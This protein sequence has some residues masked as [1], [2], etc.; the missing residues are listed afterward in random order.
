MAREKKPIELRTVEETPHRV[1]EIVR[2]EKDSKAV[3][4]MKERVELRPAAEARLEVPLVTGADAKRT[5]EPGVEAL[6]ENDTAVMQA[7]EA[8][9]GKT[10]A[11]RKPLPWGWFALLG[12]ILLGAVAW[13][14]ARM[15]GA[16]QEVEKAQQEA[17]TKVI[18]AEATDEEIERSLGRM[19]EVVRQFCL[20][21]S[22]DEM[23]RWVRH[24]ERVRPLMER[25]YTATPLKPLGYQRQ[26]GFQGAMMGT[27]NSYW[28]V[29]VVLADGTTKALLVEQDG[30]DSFR[31]DWETAV[32]YQPMPWDA[33]ALERPAG[34]TLDFRVYV[35]ED[36]FFS[37]EFANPAQYTSF[38]LTAPGADETLWGYVPKNSPLESTLR[39]A[40][41]DNPNP[42]KPVAMLLRLGLPTGLG[43]RRGVVI[44]QVLSKRWL[45]G[46]PPRTGP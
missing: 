28:V 33:Y 31:V 22:V 27:K 43:S 40:L 13:S 41:A 29:K 20:A 26:K 24:P 10:E 42:Y 9:W 46:D 4:V 23:V 1:E 16:R 19:E 36:H 3:K 34:T 7:D 25:H 32:I 45:P 39:Q 37:H 17:V 15:V 18:A 14:V 30:D 2:L 5:H 12:L 38:R 11:A 21:G 44:E 8:A 35:E 6:M